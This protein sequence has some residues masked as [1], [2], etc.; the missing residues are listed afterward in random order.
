MEDRLPS[1]K[2]VAAL[3]TD[4]I[5]KRN[6]FLDVMTESGLSELYNGWAGKESR[7]AV[8]DENGEETQSY[9]NLRCKLD[10]NHYGGA[11]F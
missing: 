2:Q 9:L 10:D 6:R 5:E 8:N 7:E 11:G 4:S 3:F 1:D